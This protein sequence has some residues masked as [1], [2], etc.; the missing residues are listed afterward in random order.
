MKRLTFFSF[1]IIIF[2]AGGC[3]KEQPH[4]PYDPDTHFYTM[5]ANINNYSF[6]REKITIFVPDNNNSYIGI[7]GEDSLFFI[8]IDFPE[9]CGEQTFTF[10]NSNS[11]TCMSL[12]NIECKTGILE[13]EKYDFNLVEGR[14]EFEDETDSTIN[15]TGGKFSIVYI[16]N[17]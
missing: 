16:I 4:G 3:K 10:P 5:T 8:T 17:Q 2:L 1:I 9:D 12:N 6:E 7:T 13:I 14:F 11:N 15:V